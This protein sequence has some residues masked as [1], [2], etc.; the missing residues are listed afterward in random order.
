MNDPITATVRMTQIASNLGKLYKNQKREALQFWKYEQDLAARKVA[1][2]PAG[3]WPGSNPEN[4]KAAEAKAYAD[5]EVLQKIDQQILLSKQL[6]S[7][8]EAEIAALEAERRALEWGI[9]AG[10][11]EALNANFI[12]IEP[13]HDDDRLLD[14]AAQAQVDTV[15]MPPEP[16]YPV[17]TEQFFRPNGNGKE[18]LPVDDGIPF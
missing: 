3:G 10:Q 14:D 11:I 12:Q 4:R 7:D 1:M 17:R 5:D 6:L 16:V 13:G 8:I 15:L 9:R 2:T 18:T